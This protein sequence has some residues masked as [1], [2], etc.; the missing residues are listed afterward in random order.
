M[1]CKTGTK[2]I[3]AQIV[4]LLS[5]LDEEQYARPLPI[6]NGSS[7]G[8]HFR[9]IFDFY[10]CLINDV[11]R[12]TIDYAR[13]ARDP[14]IEQHPG[15]A[16]DAFLRAAEVIDG[17]E[18]LASLE[19]LADFSSDSTDSRPLLKSTVGRELMFAHDH[20]VHHIA[21]IKIGFQQAFPEIPIALEVGV[22][23]STIK[24]RTGQVSSDQ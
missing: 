10:Q 6:Y 3:I 4:E 5:S 11:S 22:A 12:G 14:R 18:E 19:V 24:Y 7:L 1:D 17:F 16:R 21:I 13:R 15:Y 23:P 20:A 8:Q 9:H 2:N